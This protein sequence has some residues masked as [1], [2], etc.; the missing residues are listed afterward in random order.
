MTIFA[1]IIVYLMIFWTLLFAVLPWGNKTPEKIEEGM[2]GSAPA[3]PRIKE[4]FLICAGISALVWIVVY[5]LV[6]FGVIDFYAIS[7]DMMNEDKAR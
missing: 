1:G 6:T 4:K 3:K 7:H 5:L 2:A